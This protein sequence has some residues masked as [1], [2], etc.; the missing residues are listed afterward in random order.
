[1]ANWA[2]LCPKLGYFLLIISARFIES[3]SISFSEL[4]IDEKY[5]LQDRCF[6]CLLPG[7]KRGGV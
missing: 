4:L 7:A 5:A 1:M 3:V 2:V 6:Y